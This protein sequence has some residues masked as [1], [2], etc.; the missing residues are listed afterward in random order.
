MKQPASVLSVG[1]SPGAGNLSLSEAIAIL[2]PDLGCRSPENDAIAV[3]RMEEKR[4]VEP[5]KRNPLI[6]NFVRRHLLPADKA[7]ENLYELRRTFDGDAAVI[8]VLDHYIEI[9]GALARLHDGLLRGHLKAE[10]RNKRT[11]EI[12]A[13][14]SSYFLVER[15]IDWRQNRI[16]PSKSIIM[17]MKRWRGQAA[18][19]NEEEFDNVIID[20]ASFEMWRALPSG[21]AEVEAVSV[22]EGGSNRRS[23]AISSA[24]QAIDALWPNG[25][26][27]HLRAQELVDAIQDWCRLESHIPPSLSTIQRAI[28][29][30]RQSPVT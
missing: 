16:S 15:N 13:I 26:P 25:V 18:P 21:R 19:A 29:V 9:E 8:E 4:E 30:R 28:R 11:L 2:V 10:G 22:A 5:R 14:P 24:N 6:N 23:P 1:A 3:L 27:R 17:E 20:G 12:G 7:R